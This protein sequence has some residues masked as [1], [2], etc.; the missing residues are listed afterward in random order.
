MS[1]TASQI[2][3]IAKVM[4]VQRDI[5]CWRHNQVPVKGRAFV[6]ELGCSD[7]IGM[8]V[9]TGQFTACEV[10]TKTDRM[11]E[12]QKRFLK[13]TKDYGGIALVAVETKGG[14]VELLDIGEYLNAK[15]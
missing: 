14:N 3:T 6:G 1:L 13:M 11:S 15:S 5:Y 4:L 7:L 8:N 10:K 9:K 2:T 12:D